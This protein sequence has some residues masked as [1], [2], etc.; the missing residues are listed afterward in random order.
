MQYWQISVSAYNTVLTTPGPQL[1]RWLATCSE[2]EPREEDFLSA[3]EFFRIK[4]AY[5]NAFV[6]QKYAVHSISP[7]EPPAFDHA[8]CQFWE[9]WRPGQTQTLS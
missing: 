3:C 7:E 9:L 5:P 2:G 8:G 1:A 6:F 4:A